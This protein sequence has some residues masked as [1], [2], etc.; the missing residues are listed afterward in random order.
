MIIAVL[1]T[2]SAVHAVT[3]APEETSPALQWVDHLVDSASPACSFTYDGAALRDR[4]A[5][6]LDL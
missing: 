3:P 6:S 2:V 4:S 5:P 1:T